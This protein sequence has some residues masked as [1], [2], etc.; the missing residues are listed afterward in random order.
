[1]GRGRGARQRSTIRC[2]A[3]QRYVHGLTKIHKRTFFV[4]LPIIKKM[5]NTTTPSALRWWKRE[6]V[7]KRAFLTSYALSSSPAV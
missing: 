7:E 2:H 6:V 1:M 3:I 4:S 5:Q